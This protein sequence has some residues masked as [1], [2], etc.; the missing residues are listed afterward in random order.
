MAEICNSEQIIVHHDDGTTGIP[1]EPGLT[2]LKLLQD[3]D[4]EVAAVCGGSMSCGTCHVYLNEEML[5]S[6]PPRSA[7][8]EEL[9]EAG[10]HFEP[11]RSRLAC[12][13]DVSCLK[14]GTTV[15]V[16]PDE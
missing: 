5:A 6:L 13:V 16:A 10:D 1:I 12:Q 4:V 2:L 8:E 9:L 14:G 7:A 11:A 3:H 15:T